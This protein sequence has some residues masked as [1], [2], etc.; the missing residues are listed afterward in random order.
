MFNAFVFAGIQAQI[1][2]LMTQEFQIGSLLSSTQPP[3]SLTF[4]L[5]PYISS[6]DSASDSQCKIDFDRPAVPYD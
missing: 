5:K 2:V 3:E 4:A 1:H 6:V